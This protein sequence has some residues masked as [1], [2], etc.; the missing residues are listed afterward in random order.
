VSVGLR[1][2]PCAEF[3]NAV[4]EYVDGELDQADG[5]GLLVHLELCD[6]CREAIE[7]V[8]KQIRIHNDASLDR[9]RVAGFD[10]ARGLAKLESRL[11]DGNLERV[12]ALLYELGK[13]YF[14]AGNDSKLA[15][16]L[17]QKR[18]PIERT[19]AE[20]RR[21][22]RETEDLTK[23]SGLVAR[24]TAENLKRSSALFRGRESAGKGARVGAPSGRTSLDNARRFL[25]ECLILAPGHAHARLYLGVY[26]HRIDR[27][28]EAI[29]EYEKVLAIE[30]L[31]PMMRVMAL[32]ALGNASAYRRD[33][34]RAIAYF[35]E[36][37]SLGVVERDPRFFTVLVSLAMFHAKVGRLERSSALFGEMVGKFPDRVKD[38]RATLEQAEVFRTLL[39]TQS[40]FR[41]EL[42]S[43]YPML[44]AS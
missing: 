41:D 21:L 34:E 26:F 4:H 25:E 16:F 7:A 10:P 42:E 22:V 36:I 19:R 32:Q 11:V 5:R 33:Y 3:E 15:A 20:G 29:A 9:D 8:R 23:R 43:R 39:R 12:A 17:L 31:E 14:V 27:P 35:E 28:D 38:A 37:R 30:G 13:A 40:R 6:G 24:R 44:F 18:A 1:F 2:M